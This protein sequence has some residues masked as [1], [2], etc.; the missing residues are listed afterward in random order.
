MAYELKPCPFCGGP[1]SLKQGQPGSWWVQ[2]LSC[3][4]GSSDVGHDHA[5]DLW[6][7][8]IFPD[9]TRATTLTLIV[10]KGQFGWYI[11]CENAPYHGLVVAGNS[12]HEA[13]SKV[14]G[15]LRDLD[16]A[17]A[18]NAKPGA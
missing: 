1:A 7:R 16:L 17:I 4:A 11:T 5:I 9:R 10:E 6:N 12:R 8:R 2:C 3:M 14:D 13:L 15:A 18:S